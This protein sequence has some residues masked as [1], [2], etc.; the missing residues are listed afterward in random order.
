MADQPLTLNDLVQFH[1][2]VFLPDFE[3]I[4]D[5]RLAPINLRFD[6]VFAHFD[7]IYKRFDRL[8]SEI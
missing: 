5:S 7:A 8:E 3:R 1:R 4:V 6:D 2:Q